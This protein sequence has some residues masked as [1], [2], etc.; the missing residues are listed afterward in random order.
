MREQRRK[1]VTASIASSLLI[2]T[3]GLVP[4]TNAADHLDGP[5]VANNGAADITDDLLVLAERCP[6]D[7]LGRAALVR[8]RAQLVF[9]RNRGRDAAPGPRPPADGPPVPGQ[10]PD[11]H[12]RD[13]ARQHRRRPGAV[14]GHER[15]AGA[16]AG[17]AAATAAGGSCQAEEGRDT[18]GW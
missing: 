14:G 13:R 12:R 8:L 10:P 9:A 15:A 11:P 7:D 5:G 17:A 3:L 4:T 2:L 18:C 1:A 6:L 16:V